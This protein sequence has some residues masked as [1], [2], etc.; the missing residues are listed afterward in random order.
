MR[1]FAV[2]FA[3]IF[4]A[5]SASGQATKINPV[6]MLLPGSNNTVLQTDASGNVGWVAKNTAFSAG[7]GITISA[8]GVIVNSAPD[9]TVALTAGVGISVSGTYPNFTVTNSS[10]NFVQSLSVTG[11]STPVVNLS[12]GGGS[13]TLTAGTGIT[14]N[15]SS[16][17]ITVA[18]TA[19]A[20]TLSIGRYEEVLAANTTTVT[21]A[22]F[23]PDANT[24]VYV[25]GVYM[26]IGA[27]EDATLS[28]SVYT[29]TRTLLSGQK[30]VVR[31]FA[32][33]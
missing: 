8:A 22:G 19:T 2:L 29:F 33:N 10:P 18:A 28:G 4:G 21:V 9:Q 6:T 32:I 30:V 12:G 13:F 27:G 15:N 5:L 3:L 20:P 7:A 23:T 17:N 24:M 25:D 26:D 14:L 1:I 16:G 31:R 11:T